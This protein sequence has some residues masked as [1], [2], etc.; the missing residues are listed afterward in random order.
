MDWSGAEMETTEDLDNCLPGKL[1]RKNIYML[2][3]K[4]WREIE[5]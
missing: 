4:G 5:I 3:E 2:K 1:S